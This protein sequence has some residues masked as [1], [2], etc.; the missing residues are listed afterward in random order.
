L[1]TTQDHISLVIRTIASHTSSFSQVD[2]LADIA[3]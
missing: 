3:A 2:F 1:Y